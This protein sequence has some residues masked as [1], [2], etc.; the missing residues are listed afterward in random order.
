M[1]MEMGRGGAAERGATREQEGLGRVIALA[2]TRGSF[3]AQLT[4]P[5]ST[6]RTHLARPLPT[7]LDTPGLF[8]LHGVLQAGGKLPATR[9]VLV[10]GRWMARGK[11]AVGVP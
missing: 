10:W 2:P 9:L 7:L 1:R 8:L 6:L 5:P 3:R 11:T 4:C